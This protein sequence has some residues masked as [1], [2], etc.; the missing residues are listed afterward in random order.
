VNQAV[1]G[2]ALPLA[3]AF[4]MCYLGLTLRVAD[5]RAVLRRPRALAVGLAGQLVLLPLIGF[6][7]ARSSGLEP[8]MAVGLMVLAACP[9]GVSSGLLTHLAR[10]DVALSIALTAISS[11]AAMASL[12]LVL[13]LAL[14]TLAASRLPIELPLATA[15]RRIFVLTTVPVLAGMALRAWAPRTV[16]RIEPA[17][18]RVA[19]AL[20]VL[21][22][23]A[24]FWTQRDVLL[25][26]LPS[27]GPACV[28]LNAAVLAAAWFSSG[29][30]GLARR[31][32]VAITTECGLQNAALG[33]YV[34]VELLRTPTMS[35]PSVVYALLMNVGAL[36]FLAG[37]RRAAAAPAA[38]HPP[39]AAAS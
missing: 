34:T 36:A 5:F 3:L 32:R 26:H 17:A 39:A 21:I 8:T 14:Q 31:D 6:A 38:N 20:F 11:V 19:T 16:Q 10:G 24:T 15:V 30:A 12:P 35:V 7:V 4:I 13:D 27:L 33:I 18:G 9:G 25:A 23:L 2:A 37:M 29:A 22:V 28:M 1:V